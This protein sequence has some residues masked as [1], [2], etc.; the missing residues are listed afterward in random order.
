MRACV[1]SV[2]R[3]IP[4]D[5]RLRGR[6]DVT[7]VTGIALPRRQDVVREKTLL[8]GDEMARFGQQ[9]A[10]WA[11]AADYGERATPHSHVKRQRWMPGVKLLIGHHRCDLTINLPMAH[12]GTLMIPLVSSDETT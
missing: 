4:L 10:F 9:Q 12:R 6:P 7:S 1:E 11:R 3:H 2:R 5:S 8:S